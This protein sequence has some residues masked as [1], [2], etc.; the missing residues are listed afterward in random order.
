MGQRPGWQE[1]IT[2]LFSFLPASTFSLFVWLVADGWYWFNLFWEKSTAGWLLVADLLWEKSIA[3]WW[4]I[5][6]AN[7]T[8]SFGHKVSYF[9]STISNFV[10]LTL[11]QQTKWS[12]PNVKYVKMEV[13]FETPIVNRE[14]HSWRGYWW[15]N[16]PSYRPNS[17]SQLGVDVHIFL[18]QLQES[19]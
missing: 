18:E 9:T 6:Q 14:C 12:Y 4:L 7:R 2:E 16:L 1:L 10:Y 13:V 11:G 17:S 3:V 15:W 5:S 19:L 8:I